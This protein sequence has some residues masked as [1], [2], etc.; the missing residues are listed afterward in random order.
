MCEQRRSQQ[1]QLPSNSFLTTQNARFVGEL[2]WGEDGPVLGV[3][4]QESVSVNF[5]LHGG[6]DDMFGRA[7][8]VAHSI[9]FIP[10]FIDFI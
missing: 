4:L 5:Q 1:L 3:Q 10:A 6:G 9:H 7:V 2:F 8:H